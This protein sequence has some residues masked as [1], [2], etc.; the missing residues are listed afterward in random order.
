MHQL[1]QPGR[2]G[3]L[4]RQH[5]HHPRLGQ[6]QPEETGRL[7]QLIVPPFATDELQ[8]QLLLVALVPLQLFGERRLLQDQLGGHSH[9][10]GVSTHFVRIARNADDPEQLPL[11][12]DGQVD[13]GAH[14]L[15]L[16]GGRFADLHHPVFGQRQHRPLMTL[17][18]PLRVAGRDDQA[19]L[20]H[21]VDRKRED[22]HRPADNLPCEGV[23]ELHRYSAE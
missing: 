22:L 10:F 16:A 19:V 13:A 9:Q 7:L 6:I 5:R 11:I 23:I 15:E 2:I 12:G 21:H 20:V 3:F 8:Y 4:Q 17:M 18:E 14:P 1:P